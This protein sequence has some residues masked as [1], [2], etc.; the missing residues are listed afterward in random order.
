MK[1]DLSEAIKK[2]HDDI[3]DLSLKVNPQAEQIK[4]LFRNINDIQNK[5]L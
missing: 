5:M 1:K 3:Q 2:N 4:N